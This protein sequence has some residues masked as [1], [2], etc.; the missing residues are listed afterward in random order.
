VR[1]DTAKDDVIRR[2]LD[3]AEAAK[4]R[5]TISIVDGRRDLTRRSLERAV[6]LGIL[7]CKLFRDSDAAVACPISSR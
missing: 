1:I 5:L 4:S 7:Q 2:E 3:S 6:L